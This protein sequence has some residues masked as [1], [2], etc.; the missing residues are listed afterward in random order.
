MLN[1]RPEPV[2]HLPPPLAT[3]TPSPPTAAAWRWLPCAHPSVVFLPV[4]CP[5]L[6]T[7]SHSGPSFL[8]D[9]FTPPSELQTAAN[10]GKA[11][12]APTPSAWQTQEVQRAGGCVAGSRDPGRLWR[13]PCAPVAAVW[14]P[15]LSLSTC[16]CKG[17]T[18]QGSFIPEPHTDRRG[19]LCARRGGP[20]PRGLRLHPRSGPGRPR[21]FDKR[22]LHL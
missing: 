19:R 4:S 2:S 7:F 20:A 12:P 5:L 6:C 15:G 14:P 8:P 13:R 18:G 22:G 10:S 17:H 21:A 9:P 3:P 1:S 16:Y 11:A